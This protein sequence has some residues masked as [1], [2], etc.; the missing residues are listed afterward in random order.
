MSLK[1]QNVLLRIYQNVIKGKFH[2]ILRPITAITQNSSHCQPH[3]FHFADTGICPSQT[4]RLVEKNPADVTAFCASKAQN[5]NSFLIKNVFRINDVTG[6]YLLSRRELHICYN[7]KVLNN[8]ID[9]TQLSGG[10]YFE[11]VYRTL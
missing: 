11:I 8:L 10:K 6:L 2:F 1:T 4:T 5:I 7:V 3:I 9:P